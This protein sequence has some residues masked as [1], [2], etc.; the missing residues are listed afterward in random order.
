MFMVMMVVLV[1][2]MV[3]AEMLVVPV[4]ITMMMSIASASMLLL[5]LYFTIDLNTHVKTGNST[6]IAALKHVFHARDPKRIESLT[7][8]IRI[9]VEPKQ[10]SGDHI[11]SRTHVQIEVKNP[12]LAHLI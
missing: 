11:A 5:A 6:F 4:L 10:R 2:P 8:R 3:R 9:V 7:D 12:H 1:M